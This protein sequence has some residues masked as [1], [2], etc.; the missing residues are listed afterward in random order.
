MIRL[1]SDGRGRS[2]SRARGCVE[3]ALRILYRGGWPA[4]LWAAVPAALTVERRLFS[5]SLLP[6]GASP[7]RVGFVS[8]VHL[9]PTTPLPLAR[10][11][12]RR[13]ADAA[14][15]VLLLGGDYVFLDA[16]PEKARELA[17]LVASVPAARKLAVLG[18]HDLWTRHGL[19][20]DALARAGVELLVNRDTTI[21]EHPGVRVVG[22][23]EPWTGDIDAARAF[24]GARED[25]TL[26]VLCHSPDGLPFARR[27]L[28]RAPQPRRVLFVCG[29]THG[30]QVS[31]PWG[32]I[33][34][35]GR[36][37]KRR[38]AGMYEE[39]DMHLFVSRGV[40]GVEV[41]VRTFAR[42]EVAIFEL[43]ARAH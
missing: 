36:V 17:C 29:H 16:M 43:T 2:Y 12:F 20:E 21:E 28:A 41:P 39:H 23:D 1:C 7:L 25:E 34:V 32:P 38:P 26:L 13:V 42:P 40:G 9:G 10:E 31:T 33:I 35:P 22:L 37:G 14:L 8:D 4:R 19:L 18:N 11:A 27:A 24:R 6:P 5:L 3:S 30:G 15:D